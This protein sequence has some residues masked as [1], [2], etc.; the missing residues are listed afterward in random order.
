MMDKI[1][2]AGFGGQGVMFLGK[3]QSSRSRR[4]TINFLRRTLQ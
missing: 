1:V 3:V 4:T 2:I